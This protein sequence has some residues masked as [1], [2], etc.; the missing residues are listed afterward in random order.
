MTK[1]RVATDWLAGCSGCHM[2]LLDMDEKLVELMKRIEITS[3][4]ITD[5]KT[6]HQVDVA[7]VEGAVAN[8]AN[9]KVLKELREQA[10]TLI[11][12]GDCACF[13][14]LP[15]LRNPLDATEVLRRGYV[16]TTSTEDGHIPTDSELARLLDDVLPINQIVKVDVYI[17]GCPPSAKAIYYALSELLEGRVPVLTGDNLRFD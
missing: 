14:G 9:V 5:L 1:I 2:S 15:T 4:P 13:G 7:I 12:L 8:S 6:P 10:K 3:S 11:A 16:E 17:P